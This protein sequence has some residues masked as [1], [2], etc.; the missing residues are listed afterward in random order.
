MKKE[1]IAA[2]SADFTLARVDYRLGGQSC[3]YGRTTEEVTCE[4]V[5][6]RGPII[7]ERDKGAWVSLFMTPAIFNEVV[8]AKKCGRYDKTTINCIVKERHIG[9]NGAVFLLAE[10]NDAIIKEMEKS[11]IVRPYPKALAF[12]GKAEEVQPPRI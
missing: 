10:D 6:V 3:E 11:E 5:L 9:D 7:G 8:V 12:D 2:Y 4:K 1:I